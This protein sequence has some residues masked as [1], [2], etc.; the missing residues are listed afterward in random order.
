[1]PSS[2][3]ALS[4]IGSNAG[5]ELVLA[6][7]ALWSDRRRIGE[8]RHGAPAHGLGLVEHRERIAG[9]AEIAGAQMR[10]VLLH[11]V[12]VGGDQLAVGSRS[13]A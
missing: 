11:D 5:D 10:P 13:R 8:H 4:I 2:R 3:A 9:G 1:M 12:E 7:T 6:G